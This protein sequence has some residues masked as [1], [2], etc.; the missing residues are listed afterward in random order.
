MEDKSF[1]VL[2]NGKSINSPVFYGIKIVKDH[3]GI[4]FAKDIPKQLQKYLYFQLKPNHNTTSFIQN[5]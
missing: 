4:V 1:I 3:F 5:S 2:S